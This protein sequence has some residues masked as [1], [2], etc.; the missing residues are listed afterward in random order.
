MINL[1]GSIFNSYGYVRSDVFVN[2][3]AVLYAKECDTPDEFFV[4]MDITRRTTSEIDPLQAELHAL[5]SYFFSI[6]DGAEKNT[7]LVL[8]KNYEYKIDTRSQSVINR[9]ISEVEE[10]PYFFKKSLIIFNAEESSAI[11]RELVSPESG[12]IKDALAFVMHDY[13]RFIRFRDQDNDV[14]FRIVSKLYTKLP[15]LTYSLNAEKQID[16]SLEIEKELEARQLGDKCVELLSVLDDSQA[17]VEEWITS[18]E[19]VEDV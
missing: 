4:V 7:N 15:F 18:I 14:L 8:L 10:N 17:S 2:D 3:S 9:K 12:Q 6:T 13:T 1:M 5:L 19:G 11:K 16:L